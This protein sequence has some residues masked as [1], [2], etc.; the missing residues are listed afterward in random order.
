M[1]ALTGMRRPVGRTIQITDAPH[2]RHRV[3]GALGGTAN[4][5][6]RGLSGFSDGSRDELGD[7]RGGA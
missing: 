7:G 2:E 5:M 1:S 6:M 3:T 4:V